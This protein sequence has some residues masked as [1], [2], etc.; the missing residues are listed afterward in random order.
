[1]PLTVGTIVVW[2]KAGSTTDI[3]ST[4]EFTLTEGEATC[5]PVRCR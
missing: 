3:P 5:R 1:M 2:L 4:N